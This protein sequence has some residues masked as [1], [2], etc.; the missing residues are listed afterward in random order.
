MKLHSLDFEFFGSNEP[1][2]SLVCAAL[3]G[4]KYWLFDG[5]DTQKLKQELSHILAKGEGLLAYYATAEARCLIAL[6]FDPLNFIFVDLYAEFRMQQNSHDKYAYGHYIDEHGERKLSFPPVPGESKDNK[7]K[8]NGKKVPSNMINFVFKNINKVISSS[9]KKKMRD[10]I[11]S[12]DV[13]LIEAHREEIMDYCLED[14]TYLQDSFDALINFYK[15]SGLRNFEKDM[16]NR[17]EYASATSKC[18]QLGIPINIALLERVIEKTPEILQES[19][20]LVNEQFLTHIGKELYVAEYQPPDKKFKNGNVHVYKPVPAHQDTKSYQEL[21]KKLDIPEFPRTDTGNY[22][23]DKEALETYRY[24]PVLETLY[25]HNKTE[26]S[27][28]WF[29]KSNGD[30]FFEAYGSDDCVRPFYGIFGTQ[31]GR[32]AA[33]AK[34]FPLAM[35]SWLRAIVRPPKGW[36]IVGADFSQQEVAVAA[37]LSG[38]QN[39]MDAYNSG[40]VYLYFAKLAGAVPQ[41]ATKKSHGKERDKFKATVLGKQFGM[42]IDKLWH[43]IKYDS[44]DQSIP[45]EVAVELDRYHK[46][47]FPVYWQWVYDISNAYDRG[48]PIITNDGWVLWQDNP[49]KTSVRNSPVQGNSASITRRALIDAWKSNLQVMCQLHDALYILTQDPERDIPILKQVMRQA[50][51][52]ILGKGCIDIRIDIKTLGHEDIWVEDKGRQEWDKI[53]KHL[54]KELIEEAA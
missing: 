6:E 1:H 32:N 54:S 30:G 31:T 29:N 41:T 16:Y 48:Y 28:K 39:L 46:E 11:L 7:D 8:K 18:E 9:Q 25:N 45:R 53:H 26:S 40:D 34:T 47:T 51:E 5:S 14:T 17:G 13:Q 22:K 15:S 21:I 10:I 2:P 23:A 20:G 27:L 42:G 49:I 44:G 37:S 12:K 36:F 19:K 52:K 38:D 4:K 43:K 50:T 24:I 35:S 3:S 33:K